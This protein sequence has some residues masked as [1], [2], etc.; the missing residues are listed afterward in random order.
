MIWVF[1]YGSLMW[2]PDFPYVERSPATL[3]GWQRRFWQASPDHRG[4]PAQP[5]RVVTLV[6]DPHAQC[7]GVAFLLDAHTK[8]E[9][10][11]NL[12]VR[13][14]NGYDREAIDFDLSDGRRVS[15]ITYIAPPS[16][17]SFLG[18]E[19]IEATARHIASCVGPS[20]SNSEYLVALANE[21]QSMG[22]VD[23][24]IVSLHAAF[25]KLVNPG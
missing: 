4:T 1:G 13:E 21:L 2:R 8:S 25:K 10:L 6:A 15:G 9:V 14:Q 11:Q 3:K 7:A 18:P 24:E 17:P 12:D 20:G 22:I 19:A 5:G 16:N 23:D